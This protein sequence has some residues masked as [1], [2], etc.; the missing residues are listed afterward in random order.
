MAVFNNKK[1]M[2]GA[3]RKNQPKAVAAD[4]KKRI[5][6]AFTA[7]ACVSLLVA[8]ALGGFRAYDYMLSQPV[9]RV[10]I[11]GEFVHVDKASLAA[12]VQP[13][14]IDGF[15]LLD[16]EA[17]QQ[18]LTKNPWIVDVQ[19][20]RQWPDHI[21]I[22]VTEQKPVAKWGSKAYLNDKGELFEPQT[23]AVGIPDLPQLSGP[24]GSVEKVMKNFGELGEVLAE[25][26]LRLK[27]LA[28]NEQGVWSAHLAS[29][30]KIVFG[31]GDVMGK[32]QQLLLSR[33]TALGD[34]F[35]QIAAI[36][37]RYSSGFAVAWQQQG[38]SF[39]E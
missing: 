38:Q 26:N 6:Q 20:A 2:R 31:E 34:E 29:G 3:S 15:V 23:P 7:L 14:L 33:Q 13:F 35:D 36:D 24:A 19:V 25:K 16:I 9:N 28:L 30:M 27:S 32:L 4:F 22:T 37:M 1:V 12:Q 11:N 21:D 39:S 18:A 10:A 17:M 8:V 5:Y